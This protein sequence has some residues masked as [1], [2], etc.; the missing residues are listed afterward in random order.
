[1]LAAFDNAEHVVLPQRQR[2]SDFALVRVPV[3]LGFDAFLRM[4][5]R[6]LGNVRRN[7]KRAETSAECSAQIVQP[8]R[9]KL[10]TCRFDASIESTL[11][12]TPAGKRFARCRP[13]T[14]TPLRC[15]AVENGAHRWCDRNVMLASSW[16]AAA[17]V[18]SDRR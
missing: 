8:P 12:G 4:T 2:G 6:Q 7:A 3:V 10:M 16:S 5:D 13:N 18:R 14:N 9:C 11:A 1:M 15:A 17:A